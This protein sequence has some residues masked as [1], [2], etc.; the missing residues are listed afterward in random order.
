MDTGSVAYQDSSVRGSSRVT[1][2]TN[3][4]EV[5][6]V[7]I[8]QR[9]ETTRESQTRA[10]NTLMDVDAALNGPSPEDASKRPH[11]LSIVGMVDD[12]DDLAS[13][14]VAL[15]ARILRTLGPIK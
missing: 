13:A 12:N 10:L 8:R 15:S 11:A 4:A 14:L 9:L 7:P 3:E 6:H 5:A 2:G 1:R